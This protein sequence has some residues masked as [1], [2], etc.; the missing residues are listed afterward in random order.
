M[1]N[2]KRPPG[3]LVICV[4]VIV[5]ALSS[6]LI[7]RFDLPDSLLFIFLVPCV[8]V[9][10]FYARQVYLFMIIAVVVAAVW[11]TALVSVSFTTSLIT[12]AVASSSGLAMAEMVRV[13]AIAR[14]RAEESLRLQAL[15]L[16]QIKDH[17]TIT[18]LQGVITY[19]NRAE[20]ET[21]GRSEQ[22]IIGQPTEIYGEDAERGATQQEIVTE[23]L[24]DGFWRGEV[25][26]YATDGSE[27]I[28]DCRTQVVRDERGTLIALC[29]ISTDITE[30]KQT[31]EALRESKERF[32][33]L[34]DS[35]TDVFF[36]TDEDQRCVYWNS[37]S[38]K[39]TRVSAQ[40]AVGKSIR[41]LFPDTPQNR[42]AAEVYR[43]V[44]RTQEPQ[45]FVT[46]YQ[47]DG[48][49]LF[50]EI[51][52]Y[53]SKRGL[54]VFARE[55]G[56]RMLAQQAL[57]QER[58]LSRALADAATLISRMVDPHEVLDQLLEQVSR[59]VPNDASNVMLVEKENQVH[60]ARWR[61][62][63]RFGTEAFVSTLVF[64]LDAVPS[65]AYMIETDEP[66]V[67]SDTQTYPGWVHISEQAWLRSYAGAPIRV[68][69]VVVG[70]LNVDSATPD[71]FTPLHADILR[72][73]A[74]HAAIA[75]ENAQLY[76]AA[77]QEL[78]ERKRT[79]SA[80]RAS[81]ERYRRLFERSNDAIF[82]IN[83]HTGQYQEANAAAEKLTG[84]SV[85]ELRQ[86]TVLDVTPQGTQERLAQVL[87]AQ[88]TLEM[89]EVHYLR[90]DGVP[91]TALLDV[92][93][94]DDQT[95]FGIA[96]DITERKE[97]EERLQ[98]QDRLAAIG[99]L[100]AGIAHDFR[101]L[102]TT[103]ILYAQLGQRK[104]SLPPAVAQH[105]EVIVGEA[106]KATDLVK[107]IL[108]FGRRTEIDR[109]PLDLV[110]FVG[111]VVAVLQRTLPEN[112]HITF[113]VE[114]GA[115]V[116][117]GD[118]GRLQ[119]ALTNLALNARD[120]MPDGGTLCIGVTRIAVEPGAAPPLPEM[121]E[122][123]APPA[124]ICLSVADT[125]VGMSEEM[126]AH[127][128]EPFFTTK[129]GEGTG[130]GLA[131]VYGIVQLHA[132][133]IDVETEDGQGVTFRIYLPAATGAAEDAVET[134]TTAPTGQGETLLLVED[135]AGL[136]K[137]G[138]S[139]LADLGYRVLTAA[140]GREALALYQAESDIALLITDLV[141]PE[142]GGKALVQALRNRAPYLKALVMTGYTARESVE[143]L[144]AAGF[145]EVIRK[146]FDADSLARAVRRALDGKVAKA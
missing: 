77:Q 119:Q 64:D 17:V 104:P 145:L 65:L 94:L 90:P 102:L 91:R 48:K 121:V 36:A 126:R 43:D 128:F 140:N 82:L 11:V 138:Q 101:N 18:D 120:A 50:F 125:G 54:S 74:D 76:H 85:S 114:P 98:R 86:L 75:L 4:Y 51:S 24:R 59:V 23:T 110:A 44:L 72:A 123:L 89:G 13:V 111:N 37:A 31:E 49:D 100:A 132:G 127:L 33:E 63:E 40:E 15:V 137:A 39:L 69:D 88:Q 103:I 66:M 115:Y 2:L 46:E 47:L 107:Q 61:G 134:T 97:I 67:I 136:R 84:R 112:I 34:A 141:M 133:Y 135:N 105:L 19:V 87:T 62:Y 25:V 29:G 116:V 12:I 78:E 1:N 41:D 109:R 71:F 10:F 8:L 38:E 96:H 117:E 92:V 118:A 81:E 124:W 6:W 73:F 68:H 113:D 58:D 139:I 122:S 22:E 142:L 56:E 79:E 108:D 70:F 146:P 129:K 42:K 27:H 53:P 144:Q 99:Q 20:A 3:W 55:I 35:I 9:A 21:F 26:N 45:T 106:H 143:S 7:V 80:L 30:R 16:D 83:R 52:V 14:A 57:R 5:L 93:P 131:Q 95:V 60:V 28:M 130:L 32:R